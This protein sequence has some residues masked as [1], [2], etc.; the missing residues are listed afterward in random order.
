MAEAI[1]S[2]QV[3]AVLAALREKGSVRAAAQSLGLARS[4]VLKHARRAGLRSSEIQSDGEA[5]MVRS[6]PVSETAPSESPVQGF[7]PP[8]GSHLHWCDL[9]SQEGWERVASDSW[10][11]RTRVIRG[12]LVE[13]QVRVYD[14][15]VIYLPDWTGPRL[16]NPIRQKA[17][18][19]PGVRGVSSSPAISRPSSAR[20]RARSSAS[21]RARPAATCL[22]I[23]SPPIGSS[24]AG[25]ASSWMGSVPQPAPCWSIRPIRPALS[26]SLPTRASSI[27]SGG[28]SLAGSSGRST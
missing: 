11:D 25:S 22:T 18:P 26:A 8:A 21:S 23:T 5:Q 20:S 27:T 24:T 13:D 7:T 15:G 1:T 4:T 28:S 16:G 12:E 14:P 3:E 17:K 10:V 6:A 9:T 2:N 19:R